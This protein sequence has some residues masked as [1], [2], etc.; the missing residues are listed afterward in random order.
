MVAL[1]SAIVEL[2]AALVAPTA[3]FVFPAIYYIFELLA[4]FLIILVGFLKALFTWTKPKLAN[5]PRFTK[6][7]GSTSTF[8][9]KWKKKR[10]EKQEKDE[11]S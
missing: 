3:E 6:L 7:R 11:S 8:A 4:W 5:R 2:I 9:E 1:T 10:D